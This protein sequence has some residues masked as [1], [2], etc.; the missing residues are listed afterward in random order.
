MEVAVL[1]EYYS[2]PQF[3]GLGITD[4]QKTDAMKQ[5]VPVSSGVLPIAINAGAGYLVGKLLGYPVA[6]AVATGALGMLG[7]LGVA[8]YAANKG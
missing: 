5:I 4:V 6:G 3:S 1:G 2:M 8:I 7:L